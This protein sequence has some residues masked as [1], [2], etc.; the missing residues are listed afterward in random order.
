M[1]PFR[2]P[3]VVTGP[4]RC[5]LPSDCR[6]KRCCRCPIRS[7]P[8][9]SPSIGSRPARRSSSTKGLPV[10]TLA[11]ISSGLNTVLI[12][13]IFLNPQIKQMELR[14]LQTGT[15]DYEQMKRLR[16]EVLLRPIGVPETYINPEREQQEIL[17][18]AF[19]EDRLVACCVLTPVDGQRIQLRQMAVDTGL[20][21]KGVGAQLLAFA[22]EVARQRG[23]SELFMHARD[24]VLG[25]YEKC[26]YTV[27]GEQFFEVGIPHH[28]MYRSLSPEGG[29]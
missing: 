29:T 8:K 12:R 15:E 3:S 18:G 25:F 24:A 6:P 10:L 4:N 9:S 5:A 27:R 22:E 21:G 28:I 23:F 17:L 2:S 14:L 20:Q 19:N 7:W 16:L 13:C 11:M 26:G 1:M